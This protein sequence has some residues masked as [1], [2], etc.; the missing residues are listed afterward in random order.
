MY[1]YTQRDM[2]RSCDGRPTSTSQVSAEV[3]FHKGALSVFPLG[4]PSGHSKTSPNAQ[5]IYEQF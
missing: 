4:R 3:T 1:I 2:S 5:I